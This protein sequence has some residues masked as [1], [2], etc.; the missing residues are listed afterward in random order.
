MASGNLSAGRGSPGRARFLYFW[1]VNR[2]RR[3]ERAEAKLLATYQNISEDSSV[4]TW[5]FGQKNDDV[6]HSQ[7]SSALIAQAFHGGKKSNRG[8]DLKRFRSF[9]DSAPLVFSNRRDKNVLI[10][11]LICLLIGMV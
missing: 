7:L 6:E 3:Y 5:L 10:I 11:A 4:V 8:Q 2:T 9:P 1:G